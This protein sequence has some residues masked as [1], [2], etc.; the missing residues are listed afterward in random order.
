MKKNYTAFTLAEVLITL[1]IVGIVAALIMPNAINDFRRKLLEIQFKKTDSV[2]E[3]AL[4]N[5]KTELGIKDFTDVYNSNK[6]DQNNLVKELI[7]INDVFEKQFKYVK[8]MS[9]SQYNNFE[10]KNGI[11]HYT[12]FAQDWQYC[13]HFGAFTLPADNF[14]FY[15]LPS[16][17]LIS[18]ADFS[19]GW[20]IISVD[21]NGPQKGPNKRGYDIFLYGS[22]WACDPLMQASD[23]LVGCWPWAHKNINPI[24]KKYTYWDSL[25]KPKSYWEKLRN[26]Q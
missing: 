9:Q 16:G 17:A 13:Q 11:N 8:K 6:N 20:L 7:E 23:N 15:F 18:S 21:I 22:Y 1:G 2:I 3:Q 19:R 25:Y 10:Y 24:N 26:E 4:Q 14:Y 5:T 12:F